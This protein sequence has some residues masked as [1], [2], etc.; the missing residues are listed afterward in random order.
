MDTGMDKRWAGLRPSGGV[1]PDR[2]PLVEL[3]GERQGADAPGLE[4]A[5]GRVRQVEVVRSWEGERYERWREED[6]WREHRG[7]RWGL[8]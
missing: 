3:E 7:W 4:A 5:S 2:V 1:R 8:R 6:R